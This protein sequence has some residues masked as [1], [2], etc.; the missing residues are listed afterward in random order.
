MSAAL[1]WGTPG[2]LRYES[3]STLTLQPGTYELRV[4]ARH[5]HANDTGS[6]HTYVDVP[7]FDSQTVTLSGVVLLDRRAPTISPPEALVGI[8]DAA[9]TTRRDFTAADE[10]AALVRVYQRAREQPSPVTVSFRVLDGALKE[11]IAGETVLLLSSRPV[12]R[13]ALPA[14]ARRRAYLAARDV[15]A[16]CA[17]AVIVRDCCCLRMRRRIL[18]AA[19]LRVDAP[20]GGPLRDFSRS[21]PSP[22]QDVRRHETGERLLANIRL[23]APAS[24]SAFTAASAAAPDR[25]LAGFTRP[26][27]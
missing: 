22:V 20:R 1:P 25:K 15:S 23:C 17:P 10:I 18:R 26:S 3:V 27:G 16:G 11:V 12:R 2:Q 6:V 4:A 9:P 5:E 14:S 24:V 8:L 7:D 21:A 13:R 19:A